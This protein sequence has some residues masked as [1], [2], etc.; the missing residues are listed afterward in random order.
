MESL[1][2]PIIAEFLKVDQS[3]IVG[4][5]IIDRSAVKGSILVHRMYGAMANAGV[6]VTDYTAI[7]TYGQLLQRLNPTNNE[8]SPFV[9]DIETTVALNSEGVSSIGIDIEHIKNMPACNDYRQDE[10]YKKNFS[11]LEISYCVLQPNPIISFIG[12]FAAKEAIAKADNTYKKIPFDQIEIDHDQ[13]G[14]PFFKEFDISIS[15][16]EDFAVA[17]AVWLPKNTI[18][19]SELPKSMAIGLKEIDLLKRKLKSYSIVSIISLLIALAAISISF[20]F[21]R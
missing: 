1:I 21:F 19:Q 13:L 17:V 9:N 20:F 5:T 6:V 18:S 2:K 4:S 12:L 11:P 16:V 14:K 3:T 8:N 10:F 15:H 7:K